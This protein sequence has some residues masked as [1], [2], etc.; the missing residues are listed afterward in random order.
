MPPWS[1]CS[2]IKKTNGDCV[3]VVI[4]KFVSYLFGVEV[5]VDSEILSQ[6][7]VGRLAEIGGFLFA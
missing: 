1:S 7:A 3:A 2:I 4:A 5:E 6:G